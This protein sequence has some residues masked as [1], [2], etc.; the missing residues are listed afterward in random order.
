VEEGLHVWQSL[1][2]HIPHIFTPKMPERPS[3]VLPH[4]LKLPIFDLLHHRRVILASQSPRRRDVL[5]KMGL[6]PEI[7]P[8]TFKEDLDKKDFRG[9][10]AE[11]P[12]L[13]AQEKVSVVKLMD[14]LSYCCG[15]E[16]K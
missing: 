7:V 4:A 2:I 3:V 11:Y 12:V 10:A 1:Y 6:A 16:C 9:R 8:S 15:S 13:T 5:R 14:K